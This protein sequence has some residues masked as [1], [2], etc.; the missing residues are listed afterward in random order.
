MPER[1]PDPVLEEATNRWMRW[2]L[3]LM[4]IMV[5][6]FPIYRLTEPGQ[7]ADAAGERS[8][9]L[10]A[11]GKE[12]YAVSCTGCHGQEARGG[13][14]A[15]TLNSK[16]FLQS[17]VDEQIRSIIATGVPGT[18]MSPYSLDFGGPLTQEQ[19]VALAAYLRS[20]EADAPSVPDWRQGVPAG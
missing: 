17:A 13:L 6:A 14:A 9:E 8:A 19:I 4:A 15:P 3:I 16:E 12:L 10:A 1:P 18:T 11:Q 5:L 20:L 7:R 2:G